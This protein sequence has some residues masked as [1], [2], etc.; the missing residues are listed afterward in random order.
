M[1]IGESLSRYKGQPHPARVAAAKSRNASNVRQNSVQ[2]P[3]A[4]LPLLDTK[5]TTKSTIDQGMEGV[6]WKDKK[7][8]C[9]MPGKRC[10]HFGMQEL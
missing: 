9:R 4:L 2:L 5:K 3:S 6:A 8:I 1:C 10:Y 7:F